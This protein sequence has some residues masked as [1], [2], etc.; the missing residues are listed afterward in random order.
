MQW[1]SKQFPCH[2]SRYMKNKKVVVSSYVLLLGIL[3]LSFV[4]HVCAGELD[5][6]LEKRS[7]VIWIEGQ[8]LGNM[9]IGARAQMAFIY[10]DRKLHDRIK[11]DP[12]APKWLSWHSQHFHEARKNRK[13]LFIVRLKTAKHWNFDLSSIKLGDY[14]PTEED[15]ITRKDFRPDGELPPDTVASFALMVP[16][17][18][19]SRKDELLI[20]CGDYS[21][22]W[23]IVR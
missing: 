1:F 15:V 4:P 12:D 10:I 5:E 22:I 8:Q 9:V 17:N 19:L 7:S 3:L 11:G 6:L 14:V 23:K 20:S 13:V 21:V 18:I 2:V 16:Q